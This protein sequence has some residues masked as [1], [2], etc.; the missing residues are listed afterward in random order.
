MEELPVELP[1]RDTATRRRLAQPRN[2]HQGL[3]WLQSEQLIDW[4]GGE[5]RAAVQNPT[6]EFL[7]LRVG[8]LYPDMLNGANLSTYG[9]WAGQTLLTVFRGST[10][11]HQTLVLSFSW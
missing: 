4:L 5:K 11:Q 10:V 1:A 3:D 8:L 7:H 9:S 6:E 2:H